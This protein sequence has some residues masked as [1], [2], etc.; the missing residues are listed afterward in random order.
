MCGAVILAW[1]HSISRCESE[2]TRKQTAVE[3]ELSN[4]GLNV[5]SCNGGAMDQVLTIDYFIGV[6]RSPRR[7]CREITSGKRSFSL[8]TWPLRCPQPI[9]PSGE[10]HRVCRCNVVEVLRALPVSLKVY[11]VRK[12][13]RLRMKSIFLF[14]DMVFVPPKSRPNAADS[15]NDSIACRRSIEI[16]LNIE[17]SSGVAIR[18]LT[19]NLERRIFEGMPRSLL[20]F[21]HRVHRP[22]HPTKLPSPDTRPIDA[23][24]HTGITGCRALH[25]DER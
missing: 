8:C 23:P 22:R 15:A 2:N 17:I 6:A 14:Q 18:A 16:I 12:L 20:A 1:H 7:T 24:L 21:L 5:V 11:V 4:C 13:E 3:V 9:Y 25:K 10:A 19:W